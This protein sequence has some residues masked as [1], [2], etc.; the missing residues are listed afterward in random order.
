MSDEPATLPRSDDAAGAIEPPAEE[1]FWGKYNARF[2]CPIVS[3]ISVLAHVLLAALLVFGFLGWMSG[4]RARS[5]VSVVPIDTGD[6]ADGLPGD[7]GAFQQLGG[8]AANAA[9]ET[10]P[11]LKPVKD[12]LGKQFPEALGES[13]AIPDGLAEALKELDE[14]VRKKLLGGKRG[15]GP[16]PGGNGPDSTR[17]RGMRWVL[18]FSTKSGR[19]YLGQLKAHKA[20]V[21]IPVP[22]ENRK[23]LIIRDP[24]N[25]RTDEYATDADLADQAEKMQFQDVRKESNSAIA[26][27]LRLP[28]TPGAFWAFFPKVLEVE[29][30]RL[31]IAYQNKRAEDIRETIF[32]V[33][34]TGGEARLEVVGQ[35]LK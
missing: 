18:R 32:Q 21:M 1:E 34:V 22:S 30:A 25:P 13:S 8:V 15:A 6:S 16:G 31:E 28:F 23:M 17:A 26:E 14:D 10:P 20:V 5:A 35:R 4:G 33:I 27:A 29:M 24:A 11:E 9:T 3:A 12:E 2:E 19:D 7:G